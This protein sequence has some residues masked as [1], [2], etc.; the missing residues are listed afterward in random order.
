MKHYMNIEED[1]KNCKDISEQ[2]KNLTSEDIEGAFKLS[3]LALS[4]YDRLNE[5]RLQVNILEV[6]EKHTKSDV[7]EYLRSKM[8]LMEYIHVQSR[9]IFI[10]AKA[11]I[12][13][14]RY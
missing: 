1:L 12:K 3:Q 7:K 10:S 9:A 8:K 5:I 4:M 14:S 13:M 6:K 2:Y 11:D